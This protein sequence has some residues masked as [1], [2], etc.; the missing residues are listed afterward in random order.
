MS[1][2]TY[3]SFFSLHKA[4]PGAAWIV[5]LAIP[6]APFPSQALK[7]TKYIPC[8]TRKPEIH[9]YRYKYIYSLRIWENPKT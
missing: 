9:Y 5:K 1:Y 4:T 3:G 6:Q 2:S 7:P 8:P